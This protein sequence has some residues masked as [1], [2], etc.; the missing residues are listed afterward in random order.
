MLFFH[1]IL[2]VSSLDFNFEV[3]ITTHFA[4]ISFNACKQHN[5]N[6][7]NIFIHTCYYCIEQYIPINNNI[8]R[9]IKHVMM[10][11]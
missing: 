1:K 3:R 7:N 4:R 6:N 5:N 11:L 8:Q 2:K 9:I 10:N